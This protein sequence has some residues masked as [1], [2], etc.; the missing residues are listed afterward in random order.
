MPALYLATDKSAGDEISSTYE[1][2]HITLEESYLTHPKQTDDLVNKGDPVLVGDEIVGVAFTSAGL[3]ADY[4]AID[5]EGIWFLNVFGCVSDG[6]SDGAAQ[7]LSA[8]DPVYIKRVPDTDTV[9]LSGQSDPMH[10]RR[11]GYLLGD[12]SADLESGT[13]TLVAVKIHN[14]TASL[15]NPY[16]GA[17]GDNMEID[18]VAAKAGGQ[19]FPGWMRAFIRNSTILTAGDTLVGIYARVEDTLASTGGGLV[20]GQFQAHANNAAGALSN[21]FGVIV[22]ATNTSSASLNDMI[23]LA[24]ELSGD[25]AAP[26]LV[27][28]AIQIMGLGTAGARQSWF[29]TET[30]RGQGL[31]ADNTSINVNRVFE[32]P[33]DIDGARFCIPVIPWI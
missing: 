9:I 31:K 18:V 29:Q 6:T 21:I 5:T 3:A 10:Y 27:Q 23:G 30:G 14:Q 13:A 1:G 25:G 26:A 7:V 15:M 33:I 24:I 11:F 17:F 32:I 28:T 2:R 16:I 8:G 4:I 19:N 20:A 22:R 12:V